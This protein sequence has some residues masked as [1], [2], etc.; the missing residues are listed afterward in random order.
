MQRLARQKPVQEEPKDAMRKPIQVAIKGATRTEPVQKTRKE[1]LLQRMRRVLAE[2]RQ[3]NVELG[4]LALKEL[5]QRVQ[6][7][8]ELT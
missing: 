4:L 7:A 2:K 3:T 6:A 1:Q 8:R 5:T